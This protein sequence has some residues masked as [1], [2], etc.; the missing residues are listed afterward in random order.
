M[1]NV[2]AQYKYINIKMLIYSFLQLKLINND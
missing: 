1:L 2:T